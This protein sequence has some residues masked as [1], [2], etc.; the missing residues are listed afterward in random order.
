MLEAVMDPEGEYA[1][2]EEFPLLRSEETAVV[3]DPAVVM[4]LGELI[5]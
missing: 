5:V 3:M 2:I 1:V 4:D